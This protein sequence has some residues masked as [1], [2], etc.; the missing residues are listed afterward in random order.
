MTNGNVSPEEK[1]FNIIQK[2]PNAP[3]EP[4]TQAKSIRSELPTS[5]PKL[6]MFFAK[7]K[8]KPP[9]AFSEKKLSEIEPALI[10]KALM[11]VLCVVTILVLHVAINRRPDV[12]TLTSA[13][14]KTQVPQVMGRE[15][16]PFREV[17]YYLKASGKRDIFKPAPK[18]D[19]KVSVFQ[20]RPA[21]DR[22]KEKTAGLKVKGIAWGVVPKV[23]IE[24]EGTGKIYFLKEGQLIGATGVKVKTILRNKVEIIYEEEVME[25][26]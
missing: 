13:L 7:L 18:T 26:L 20:P 21:L 22:L 5:I 14:S 3:V 6:K 1:L 25:L 12:A 9:A 19:K 4:R 17:S 8:I 24:D 23:M 15:I 2:G 10:N 11:A 16:E